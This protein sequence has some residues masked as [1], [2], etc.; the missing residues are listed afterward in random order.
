MPCAAEPATSDAPNTTTHARPIVVA[1]SSKRLP[2]TTSKW[3]TDISPPAAEIAATAI[4]AISENRASA[5]CPTAK[6]H[7]RIV[8]LAAA[9]ARTA[10]RVCTK[11]C[12]VKVAPNGSGHPAVQVTCESTRKKPLATAS[13]ID[14]RHHRKTRALER[15]RRPAMAISTPPPPMSSSMIWKARA[16]GM[17]TAPSSLT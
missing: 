11:S 14:G 1:T 9:N 6:A 13:E 5:G 4:A 10:E 2:S 16:V 17:P 8:Q 7:W 12:R 3:N 15:M